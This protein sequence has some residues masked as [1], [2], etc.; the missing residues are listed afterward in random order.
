MPSPPVPDR[1]ATISLRAPHHLVHQPSEFPH[2]PSLLRRPGRGHACRRRVRPRPRRTPVPHPHPPPRRH[3]RLRD[4]APR[5]GRDPVQVGPRR[6]GAQVGGHAVF[7]CASGTH[8]RL[9]RRVGRRARLTCRCG[10]GC[11]G[12]HRSRA[13]ERRGAVPA[14]AAR[15]GKANGRRGG[16]AAA[17]RGGD[18]RAA[19]DPSLRA[20]GRRGGGRGESGGAGR[21]GGGCGGGAEVGRNRRGGWPGG[22]RA[23]DR[24]AD[25]RTA[26]RACASVLPRFSRE[27]VPPLCGLRPA[28]HLVGKA[29]L[30]GGGPGPGWLPVDAAHAGGR[31]AGGG[32]GTDRRRPDRG[33]RNGRGPGP[34]DDPVH[35]RRV[36]RDC[37]PGVRLV[38]GADAGG[39][40]RT[41][42]RR[43]LEGG[44]GTRQDAARGA[45][46][47]ARSGYAA[48][49]GS[50]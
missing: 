10:G 37:G 24:D 27:L 47:A 44:A 1:T 17:L 29:A 2:V 33:R 34:R 16:A 11:R 20:A 19:R 25:R 41:G 50:H 8:A 39:V 36:D 32:R 18:P 43:G 45:G 23:A 9:P 48:G 12:E 5:S 7:G 13:A 26:G 21:R 6:A 4:L 30:R 49:P 15:A 22:G 31:L 46:G 42:L 28:R 35:A 14:G 3:R 40:P 38:R